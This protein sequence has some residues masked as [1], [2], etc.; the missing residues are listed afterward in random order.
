[1]QNL[2]HSLQK[3]A[4]SRHSKVL[5][6][7]SVEFTDEILQLSVEEV[8]RANRELNGT[9]DPQDIVDIAV[10]YDGTW[11]KRGHTSKYGI[12]AVI[13]VAT[14]LVRRKSHI[15]LIIDSKNRHV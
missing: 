13:D 12:G 4:F 7:D 11:H 14:G 3:E 2:P 1:L 8:K 6:E 15:Q 10:S 9:T 5:T